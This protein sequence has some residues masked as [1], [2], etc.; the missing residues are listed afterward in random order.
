MISRFFVPGVT[1]CVVMLIESSGAFSVQANLSPLRTRQSTSRS[2]GSSYFDEDEE[3]RER[4]FAKVRRGG[5]RR[6]EEHEDDYELELYKKVDAYLSDKEAIGIDELIRDSTSSIAPNALLDSI[7]PE[8]TV[9]RLP[10][11]IRDPKFWIDI[12][13]FFLLL[14]IMDN[15]VLIDQSSYGTAL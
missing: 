7:D 1:L 4:E 2:A 5:R 14:S 11:L 13:L 8:G 9:E 15:I 10:D 3:E 6:D 12:S